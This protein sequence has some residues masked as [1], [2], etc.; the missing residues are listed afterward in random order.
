M[1]QYHKIQ[2][3]FKRDIE[4]RTLLLDRFSIPEFEYLKNNVWICTEKINGTN[5]RI[6]YD[7]DNN[8]S[9]KG[10]TDNAI[11]SVFLLDE[12]ENIFLPKLQLFKEIYDNTPVCF[13]GEGYG[14]KIQK[15]G[16]Y[17]KV[18]SFILFDIRIGP[19]WIKRKDLE[20]ISK[21]FN[22]DIVP[23]IFKGSLLDIVNFVRKGFNSR[24]GDFIAEGI[25]AIPEI[26]LFCRNGAR[27]ITK[28]KYQDF[29]N[30]EEK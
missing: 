16:K 9:I 26:D 13:Y 15:G 20:N 29:N 1:N 3:I 7:G 19:W 6:I 22:I 10:K 27:I 12:L 24:W 21:Q 4:K 25:V 18:C 17:R 5:I 8:I 23:I 14:G 28:L 2:T 30:M 11:I